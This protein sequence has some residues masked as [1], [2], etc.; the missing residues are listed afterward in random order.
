MTDAQQEEIHLSRIAIESARADL[1]NC[2]QRIRT[3][4]EELKAAKVE[5][6]RLECVVERAIIE[7]LKAQGAVKKKGKK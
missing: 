6:E 4:E 5:H 3:L 7:L 2:S 1:Y